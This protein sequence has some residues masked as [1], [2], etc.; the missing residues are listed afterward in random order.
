[1]PENPE[2]RFQRNSGTLL[3]LM[4]LVGVTLALIFLMS[5]V[6]PS[7]AGILFLFAAFYVFVSFHYLVWGWWL[8][9]ELRRQE[10]TDADECD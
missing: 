5:M 8:G 1:M 2:V 9:P 6:L 10:E 4:L 3:V 7:I